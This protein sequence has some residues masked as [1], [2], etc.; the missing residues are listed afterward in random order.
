MPSLLPSDCSQIG[1]QLHAGFLAFDQ[2]IANTLSVPLSAGVCTNERGM[3]TPRQSITSATQGELPSPQLELGSGSKGAS[4][5]NHI[6]QREMPEA[7]VR[8]LCAPGCNWRLS[9]AGAGHLTPGGPKDARG[10]SLF[11]GL[12]LDLHP[13]ETKTVVRLEV[14]QSFWDKQFPQ[15]IAKIEVDRGRTKP[16][17]FFSIF[18]DSSRKEQLC[19]P[20]WQGT[21]LQTTAVYK[22]WL[23][24]LGP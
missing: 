6:G 22:N 12:L 11:L 4:P 9:V 7:V 1:N 15:P 2:P 13:E 14:K 5:W 23:I 17:G 8:E 10:L 20:E 24:M 21:A 18:P 16:K 3:M 19:E